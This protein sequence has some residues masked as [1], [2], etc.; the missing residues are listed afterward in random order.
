VFEKC[1]L[2]SQADG[3]AWVTGRRNRCVTHRSAQVISGL[4]FRESERDPLAILSFIAV[5]GGVA[6]AAGNVPARGAAKV[7]AMAALRCE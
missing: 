2:V 1:Q 6:L 3:I 7:D 5:L 4:L